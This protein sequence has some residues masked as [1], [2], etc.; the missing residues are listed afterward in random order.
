MGDERLG[1]VLSDSSFSHTIVPK[2]RGADQSGSR[3][4]SS[5][6][7]AEE[8]SVCHQARKNTPGCAHSPHETQAN[9][10]CMAAEM[11]KSNTS[12]AEW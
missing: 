5:I 10:E 12:E 8:G 2:D 4:F 11:F 9:R 6:R 1:A 7:G 3:E